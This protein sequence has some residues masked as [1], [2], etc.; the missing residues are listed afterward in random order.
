MRRPS[1]NEIAVMQNTNGFY[2]AIKILDIK[3]D[4]RM[5]NNDEVTFEYVIQTNGSPDF[6]N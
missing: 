5:D 1:I 3:D 4:T 2:S 6:T